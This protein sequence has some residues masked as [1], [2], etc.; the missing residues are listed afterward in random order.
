MFDNVKV[1]SPRFKTVKEAADWMG[2]LHWSHTV[3]QPDIIYGIKKIKDNDNYYF[4]VVE[5]NN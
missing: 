1:V 5:I 2:I 3:D 4:V